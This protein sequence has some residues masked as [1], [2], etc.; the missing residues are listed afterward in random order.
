MPGSGNA[1]SDLPGR[2][3]GIA[4]GLLWTLIFIVVWLDTV[5][6]FSKVRRLLILT[7]REDELREFLGA[8]WRSVAAWILA[9]R[10]EKMGA[11]TV[12]EAKEGRKV[13]YDRAGFFRIWVDHEG[14]KIYVMHFKWDDP[15]KPDLVVCGRRASD[16]YLEVLERGLV[17]DYSHAAYLGKELEKA[18]I[19][20]RLGKSYIQ[21]SD[22]FPELPY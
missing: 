12:A 11:L 22:L 15:K 8:K 4:V 1:L 19:A 5:W 10:D 6:G 7:K 21:D 17:S 2:Y 20:L 13:Q 3:M 14:E 9:A 18:E 16:I